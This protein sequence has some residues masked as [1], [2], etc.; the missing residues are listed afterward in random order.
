M[1]TN[2]FVSRTSAFALLTMALCSVSSARAQTLEWTRQL[3]TSESDSGWSV[4]ADGLGSVY[5]SGATGG[6]LG[7]AS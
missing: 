1:T 2:R 6:S 5:I 4:S 3:G 7:V